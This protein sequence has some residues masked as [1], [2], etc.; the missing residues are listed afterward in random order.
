MNIIYEGV[1]ITNSIEVKKADIYDNAGGIADSLELIFA[2]TKGL[3]SKWK[4]QKG[5][6][7]QM[8]KDGTNS[9]TMF[10]DYLEQRRGLFTIKAISIP[11]KAK[12]PNTRVWEDIRLY[13]FAG[14][15]ANKYGFKLETHGV[16]NWQYKRVDQIEL[17]DFE[18]LAYRCML[19]GYMLKL[20]DNKAIIYGEQ[21]QEQQKSIK[22]ISQL[23]IDGDFNFKSI[24]TGLFECCKVQHYTPSEIIQVEYK[25]KPAPGGAVLKKNIYMSSKAEGERYAKGFLRAV[26][27][28]EHTGKITIE[29]DSSLAAGC[30]IDITGVGIADGKYFIEQLATR[31]VDNKSTLRLRRPL[32]GY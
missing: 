7:V 6:K 4:P 8:Q 29:S 2:D 17:T 15:I 18:F 21:Y 26:N 24:S 16:E 19:E 31:L 9:G 14:E 27:K 23:D 28:Y 25:P 10:I 5:H 12:A 20:Y 32:E 1:D 30:N 3:W 11:L 13:E 22:A